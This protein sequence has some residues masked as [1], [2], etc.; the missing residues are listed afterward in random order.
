[1]TK[2]PLV[3]ALVAIALV[4]CAA[5]SDE[6]PVSRP[7]GISPDQVFKLPPRA[8]PTPIVLVQDQAVFQAQ[9]DVTATPDLEAARDPLCDGLGHCWRWGAWRNPD[10]TAWTP[11]EAPTAPKPA[12][13]LSGSTQA[14]SGAVAAPQGGS[15]ADA[16]AACLVHPDRYNWRAYAAA[17]DWPLDELANVIAHESTGDLCAVNASSGATCWIQQHPGG[18]AFLDPATCMA[19]GYSKWVSGGRSFYAHWYAWW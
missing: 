12:E 13:T 16:M 4:S 18:V 8:T 17:Y 7:Q 5:P 11:Q 15:W 3:L 10:D 9:V 19:Q 2:L 6:A 14:A 1:V